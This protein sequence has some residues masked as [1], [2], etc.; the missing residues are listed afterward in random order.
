VPVQRVLRLV[1]IV[2]VFV[3]LISSVVVCID[4]SRL[5][6]FNIDSSYML[7]SKCVRHIQVVEQALASEENWQM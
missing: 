1:W 3:I 7:V 5:G 2:E 6:F 4:S